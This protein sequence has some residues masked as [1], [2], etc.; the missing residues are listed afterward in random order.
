MEPIISTYNLSA[1]QVLRMRQNMI[2]LSRGSAKIY[3][4]QKGSVAQKDL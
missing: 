2:S 3:S 4:C 1:S